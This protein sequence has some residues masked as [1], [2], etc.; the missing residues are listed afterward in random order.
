MLKEKSPGILND[1]SMTTKNKEIIRKVNEGFAEGD[2]EKILSYVTDDVTWDMPGTFS[3]A[4]KDAF[5]KELN[6]DQFVG[7]PMIRITNEIAEDDC[8]AAEGTVQ[9]KRKDGG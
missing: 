8:V 2:T 7:V 4:G 3:H 1:K 5:R 6:N 9:C